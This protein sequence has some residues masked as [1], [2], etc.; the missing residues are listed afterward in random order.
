[1]QTFVYSAKDAKNV[2]RTGMIEAA[3]ERAAA[4]ILRQHGL[5][6]V[7]LK[8]KIAYKI[9]IVS[10]RL[11]KIPYSELVNFTRQLATMINAGLILTEAL[12]L[13]AKQA[14]NKKFAAII[15][16]IQRQVEGGKSMANALSSYPEV[17]SRIYITLVRAGESAGVL[18]EVLLRLADNLE[19][20]R[21]FKAK[22]RGA[23][24]YPTIILVAMV[25][26]IFI[27]LVFVIPRL[28]ELYK[29]F[30]ASLPLPTK[31][32]IGLSDFAVRF[33]WLI[34]ILFFLALTGIS[35][36]TKS[37]RGRRLRDETILKI[38]VW[39]KLRRNAILAEF[40]RTLALL[41]GAGIS[42]LE[43]LKAVGEALGNVVYEQGLDD[44]ATAVEKGLPLATALSQPEVFPPLIS[45]MVKTGEETGK[46]D[47]V[48]SRV[49]KYFESE[50]EQG[51]KNLTTAL[52]PLILIMLAFGV[53]FLILAVILPIYNLTAQF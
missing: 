42:I 41:I 29:E 33:W 14:S 44:A 21:E 13:L 12:D 53:A 17:F 8:L 32:L 16:D 51:V 48:L 27:M 18:D 26:V 38:P 30:G 49:A 35:R 15:S 4:A 28:T 37:G 20:D 31:I 34:G 10:S 23:L 25:G 3:D 24:I 1:M 2:T 52:E 7:E 6:P 9:P 19:K 39:G 47:D 43:A 40:A 46:L 5:L 11:G 22:I 45:Q 50:A 36:I